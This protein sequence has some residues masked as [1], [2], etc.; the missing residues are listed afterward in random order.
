M[1][2]PDATIIS[3][4]VQE[5]TLTDGSLVYDVVG[6]SD[7]C[8]VT[9]HCVSDLYAEQLAEALRRDTI[10][11]AVAERITPRPPLPTT[12]EKVCSRCSEAW[13]ADDEFF[14]LQPR[15]GQP[16]RLAPWCRACESDH[17]AAKRAIAKAAGAAP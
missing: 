15:Q 12:T 4:D 5:K 7:E 14:R 6:T 1:N 3:W 9:F 10:V 2:A 11:G 17:A 16:A 8:R 13:P